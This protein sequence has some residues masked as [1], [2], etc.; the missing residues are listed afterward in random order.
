[1]EYRI[2]QTEK[3]LHGPM[4]AKRQRITVSNRHLAK[5]THGNGEIDYKTQ[6]R[7]QEATKQKTHDKGEKQRIREAQKLKV[8]NT[9]MRFNYLI[10][11]KET[12]EAYFLERKRKKEALRLQKEC[13]KVLINGETIIF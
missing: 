8:E 12:R 4:F 9:A 1:M 5:I 3:P 10:A 7:A 2:K 6:I 13:I 11:S